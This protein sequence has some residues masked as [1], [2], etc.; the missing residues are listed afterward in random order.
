[1]GRAIS[2]WTD[3]KRFNDTHFKSLSTGTIMGNLGP[4]DTSFY[5]EL[6]CYDQE[7]FRYTGTPWLFQ[8][9]PVVLSDLSGNLRLGITQRRTDFV[10]SPSSIVGR[11][12]ASTFIYRR[13][14]IFQDRNYE[15]NTKAG[16]VCQAVK[17]N[18]DIL[19]MVIIAVVI[20]ILIIIFTWLA[21][22]RTGR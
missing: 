21:S 1:M 22:G 13:R 18:Y 11:K 3:F 14:D 19:L 12:I 8:S 15:R 10:H 20:I 17:I 6:S 9:L 2:V 16:C 5:A 4:T 7:N